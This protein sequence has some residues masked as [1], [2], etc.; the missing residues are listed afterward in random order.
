M[1][2]CSAVACHLLGQRGETKKEDNEPMI[3]MEGRRAYPQNEDKKASL[4]AIRKG[5]C[6][7][8]RKGLCDVDAI[9]TAS[10]CFS[11]SFLRPRWGN[12]RVQIS[13]SLSLLCCHSIP[14]PCQNKSIHV[15]ATWCASQTLNKSQSHDCPVLD[16][17]VQ[18]KP[19]SFN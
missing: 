13:L 11:F 14:P 17:V 3:F 16:L 6:S 7:C 2:V 15:S 18:L 1:D 8:G 19:T 12:H 5:Q 10:L 9:S 4:I